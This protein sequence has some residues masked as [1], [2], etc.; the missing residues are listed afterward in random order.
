MIIYKLKLSI[1]GGMGYL[2]QFCELKSESAV[3]IA[4]EIPQ[5]VE[6]F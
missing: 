6:G 3:G 1:L 4:V 2:K 5:H